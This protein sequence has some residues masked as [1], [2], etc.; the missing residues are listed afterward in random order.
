MLVIGHRGAAALAPENTL[1]AFRVGLENDVDMLEFDVRLTADG[2][3]VVIHDS[4]TLRTHKKQL[5]ISRTTFESLKRKNLAP[6]VPSLESVFD[7][8][9]GSVLLNIELKAKGSGAA[10]VELLKRKYIKKASDWDNV[11][12]SSFKTR[13]LGG[14]RELSKQANLALL[15]LANPFS[16]VVHQRKLRLAAVGFHRLHVNALSLEIAKQLGLFTYAYTVNR[17]K[18]AEKLVQRGIDGI[19]TDNPALLKKIRK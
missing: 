12:F 6:A 4:D 1:E 19:V 17:P 2:V 8:F 7:E 5:T 13:E 18:A 3:P 10:V 16:F 14:V 15:H 11:I 9:F